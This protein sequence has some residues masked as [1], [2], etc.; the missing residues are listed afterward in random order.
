[1]KFWVGRDII[2]GLRSSRKIDRQSKMTIIL[3]SCYFLIKRESWIH[4]TRS[5][6]QLFS[7]YFLE[8]SSRFHKTVQ[9]DKSEFWWSEITRRFPFIRHLPFTTFAQKIIW[10]FFLLSRLIWLISDFLFQ[11]LASPHGT[12]IWHDWR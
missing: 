1:M 6:I 5:N 7:I 9:R 12:K 3:D 11:S 10:Q 4:S 8:G 2:L